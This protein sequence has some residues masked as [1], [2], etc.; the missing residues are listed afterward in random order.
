MRTLRTALLTTLLCATTA[1]ADILA[2]RFSDTDTTDPNIV[3]AWP[4]AA[5]GDVAPTRILG[6]AA[7]GLRGADGLLHDPVQRELYVADFYGRA[8]R[9]Y[10]DDARGNAAPKRTFTSVSLGQP[11]QMALAGSDEIAVI[12]TLCCISFYARTAD[13]TVSARRTIGGNL[14]QIDN[15]SGIAYLPATDEIA[16]GDYAMQAGNQFAGEVLI[17]PRTATGNV[18]PSRRIAGPLAQLGSYIA[19]LYYDAA[20]APDELAVLAATNGSGSPNTGAI[21]VHHVNAV[22]SVAPLRVIAGSATQ[23]L[24]PAGI[25]YSA[26]GSAFLVA[27]GAFGATPALLSFPRSGTGDLAPTTR[28]SGAATGVSGS[29]GWYA[30]VAYAP[31]VVFANGFETP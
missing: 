5:N 18:A 11:R 10:A 23:L 30:I 7:T 6:G 12:T 9:V 17:F 27:S 25:T 2:G 15:P 20:V 3:S 14:T 28:I 24:N 22:N 16:I 21:V 8:I 13:G 29:N 31:D 19:G 4:D 1:Q 26:D